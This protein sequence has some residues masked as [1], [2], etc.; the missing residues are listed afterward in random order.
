[1]VSAMSD[2]EARGNLTVRVVVQHCMEPVLHSE[3]PLPPRASSALGAAAANAT[4]AA[5]GRKV[6]KREYI[7]RMLEWVS[8]IV[9]EAMGCGL[10]DAMNCTV[11]CFLYTEGSWRTYLVFCHPKTTRCEKI[12]LVLK[13]TSIVAGR[14]CHMTTAHHLCQHSMWRGGPGPIPSAV[15]QEEHAIERVELAIYRCL[16]ESMT[17]DSATYEKIKSHGPPVDGFLDPAITAT[18]RM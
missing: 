16:G 1:M 13:L 11:T 15:A 4:R 3:P 12:N 6:E 9:R 7:F 10:A 17:R 5:T 8:W 2:S 18:H 14:A